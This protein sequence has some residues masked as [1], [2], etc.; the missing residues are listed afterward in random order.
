MRRSMSAHSPRRRA[1]WLVLWIALGLVA[2]GEEE[3]APIDADL[4]AEEL[5]DE[6]LPDAS[7]AEDTAPDAPPPTDQ[8]RDGVPDSA[9]NCP[10]DPNADQADADGDGLGDACDRCPMITDEAQ[11]DTDGDG[12]GDAC[13][14]CP[15]IA[16][17]D[18]ADRDR[19][20]LGDACDICPGDSDPAQADR[21]G[22]GAGDACDTC[23][24]D[25][26]PG[27]EDG[28]GD[29]VG[30]LCQDSDGDGA[31]DLDDN[32]PQVPNLDQA[33]SDADGVGDACDRCPSD[34]D[35][36]Q[37]DRDEDGVGDTCDSCPAHPNPDQIDRDSDGLG[38]PCDACP[39][40]ADP[41]QADEDSDGVG[42]ACDRCL[43]VADPLQID[44]DS[45]R[46]GDACDNCPNVRN[47]DQADTDGDGPG[48]ACDRCPLL[49]DPEQPDADNDGVGDACDNCPNIANPEQADRDRD[50]LGDV[51]QDSDRDGLRDVDDNCPDNPN[52]DQADRDLDD[53]G[54][55]CDNC[56]SGF[57]PDQADR[58]G[59]GDGALAAIPF[60]P[61]PTPAQ[62]LTLGDEQ[63]SA[64]IPLGFPFSFFGQTYESARVSS[65][66]F[67]SFDLANDDTG[68]CSGQALPSEEPPNNLIAAYWQDLNPALGG[69]VTYGLQGQTPNREF[70]LSFDQVPH[71]GGRD[72]V[73]FQIIL[74]EDN[75]QVEIHCQTCVS[76]RFDQAT[77]G[78]KDQTG[79]FSLSAPGRS[80][81]PLNLRQDALRFTTA[82]RPSDGL[83]DACDNCPR[84]V[85]PDQTD[86][87]N[88]GAGD[89]C[90]V[91]AALPN[92][93]QRDTDNDGV[94][95][96]CDNCPALP[97]PDQADADNDRLGDACDI[98]PNIADANQTDRDGDGA[99]DACDNC[100]FNNN[101]D[102][103]DADND[104]TGD[105]CEDDDADGTIN[106][107]D[108]CPNIPNP[109]Q[110]DADADRLG[111]AC[112]NCPNR[113]NPLQE[114]RDRYRALLET[115]PFSPRPN[116]SQ[117]ADLR[118]RLTSGP[119][120]LG[121][122]FSLFGRTYSRV[123]LASNGFLTFTDPGDNAAIIAPLLPSSFEPNALVAGFW[124]AFD[125]STRGAVRYGTRGQAPNREF[126]AMY[127]NVIHQSGGDP[128]SF[129]IILREDNQSAEI[130]C[131]ACDANGEAHTQGV[132][133]HDG[134]G[135]G[136]LPNRNSHIF[137]LSMDAIR[138]TTALAQPDPYGDACDV[139]PDLTDPDQIDGDQDGVGD[140]CDNCPLDANIDQLDT[141]EDG[142]G[143]VCDGDIDGDELAD[144]ADN[145]PR[146]ANPDQADSDA[147]AVGNPCDN[148]PAAPNPDQLDLDFDRRGDACDDDLDGDGIDNELDNC[149]ADY[150]P[151]QSDADAS[152]TQLRAVTFNPRPNPNQGLGLGDEELSSPIAL[153][154][155]VTFYGQRY[156]RLFVSSNGFV[157]FSDDLLDATPTPQRLPDGN[158][159][160][161]L[162]AAYWSDLNPARG[163]LIAYGAQGQ[164]PNREFIVSFQ[165][166]PHG[167]GVAAPVS[168][169]IVFFEAQ[170]D[171]EIICIRCP[172]NGMS[173]T[174]GV[175]APRSTGYAAL[176]DRN[177]NNFSLTQ[178]AVRF[179]TGPPTNPDALGDGLGDLCDS[180]PNVY[181]PDQADTDGD[182][183]GDACQP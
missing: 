34:S 18:Q 57:N 43:G 58:D 174:Q 42:D 75:Q 147:D 152:P 35:P 64:P 97:N 111:D 48:D 168:F 10:A 72:P 173:H 79:V 169:Q 1:P 84:A 99:G 104:R 158:S 118:Q 40:D 86:R 67:L 182:G 100:P 91:C 129:Q 103:A 114:N 115:I 65:N 95:D 53:A 107:E 119:I 140:A 132:E 46:V 81:A 180:C 85:N 52:P 113:R 121:F 94:G 22:D 39:V 166:V 93:N 80:A 162:V 142:A 167:V 183:V 2:C 122:D 163:G 156:E 172:S 6:D 24:D 160:N 69:T 16:N 49:S 141:N 63:L 105:A 177:R 112:D 20:G 76:G 51:C 11:T 68:C 139:C 136:A 7:D 165:D 31:L 123:W 4:G 145:C 33:D 70:V 125:L 138:V 151:E 137:D 106:V 150:N 62:T 154:F 14:A 25:S 90:D 32:C 179:T 89:A 148:C 82:A 44:Q 27:Q 28:D 135:W 21:D 110:R 176:E 9:D 164:A 155:P 102:Q 98:C 74:R 73:S 47:P 13:D 109:D 175:E 120:D 130:H 170:P 92:G 131:R 143:D 37:A 29:G 71:L 127:D 19:D 83:G 55:A 153:P 116:P 54:D 5:G 87:D 108:N 181:N 17:P 30:D 38:E 149:L 41:E 161:A 60:S 159:P 157:T 56:L 88:D 134:Q 45:D 59:G 3:G 133:A 96:P 61:R 128:V 26:D 78:L 178:D 23:P 171:V 36:A 66:G 15:Q 117:T 77:Q 8:D 101:P 144:D 50:G 124:G 146:L 12:L 126:V